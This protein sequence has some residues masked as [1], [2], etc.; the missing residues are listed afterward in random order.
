MADHDLVV[1][2]GRVVEAWGE[3]DAD[4]AVDG[5]R[6]AAVGH[7]LRGRRELDAGGLLVLPGAVDGHVHM[8]TER[9][10]DVY[11]DTFATG[12]VAAAFGG[13]TAIVD[14]AQVEPGT[15]L[16]AGLDARLAEA[17]GQCTIDYGL[18]VN[19]REPSRERAAEI[20]A[21]VARGCK[22][23][24]LFMSY[25]TY[26][27]PDEILLR[28]MQQTARL[29]ALAIVH[30]ENGRIVAELRR[31]LG[32]DGLADPRRFPAISP[33]VMEGEAVHRA[34]ALARLAGTRLLV[35]HL[36]TVDAV[37]ELRAARARGQWARGEALLHHLLVGE[38][39]YADPERAPAFM[40]T[41][42][43]RGAEHRDALWAALADGTLDIVSTDHGPRRRRPDA[44]G[45][46][47]P[48]PGTS[49]IEVRLGLM[50]S[51]GVL[52]GRISRSR[53][54]ELCCTGP[55]RLHG[56]AGKGRLAPG[57]DA[58]IVLFD[59]AA[60]L[61]LTAAALHSDIDHATYE[62]TAVTGWPVTTISRGEVIVD[63]GRL[64]GEPGRGRFL[65]RRGPG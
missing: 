57:C 5:E 42:P 22:G 33:P 1:R 10:V 19:L 51:A 8:R 2:G 59:P 16:E 29:G 18:H 30:A 55:A 63:D 44:A 6:I 35:F 53:W 43:L 27:L 52:E 34:L 12:T 11:D 23:I 21:V 58:D 4:V 32:E 49:G 7:G 39:V 46:P 62:G 17:A 25:P 38:D 48:Q 60:R 47:R 3:V 13:V 28:A 9:P 36:T 15:P 20:P 54:V 41:P 26:M 37:R 31:E 56:L 24:K 40:G 65:H 61:T 50:H 14:Q 45:V 64:L